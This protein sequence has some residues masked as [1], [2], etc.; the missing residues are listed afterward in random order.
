MNVTIRRWAFALLAS[1]ALGCADAAPSEEEP[2]DMGAAPAPAS[3]CAEQGGVMAAGGEEVPCIGPG[4]VGDVPEGDYIEPTIDNADLEADQ[5]RF[6]TQDGD[7]KFFIYVGESKRIGVRTVDLTGRPVEGQRIGFTLVESDANRPS[8]ASL[9]AQFSATNEF[10]VADIQVTA[11]PQPSFFY[12]LMEA[13]GLDSLRYQISVVQRPEGRDVVEPD[14]NDPNPPV[15]PVGGNCMET[16]GLYSITNNYEPGRF[17]GDG[18]F[19]ALETIHQILSDPGGFVGDLI[20]DRIGG[21]WG[22]LIRGAIRPVINYLY[23]YVVRNYA[24]D[25]LRATLLIVEDVTSLLV[26]LEIQGE[27]DLGEV[28]DM[29]ELVGV[30]RWQTLIFHWRAGCPAGDDRCGRF[31]VPLERLGASASETEFTARVVRSFGPVATMEIDEHRLSLNLGVAVIWFLQEVI[32]PARFNVRSFGELLQLVLPCDAVGALAADYLSGV[33]IIG[34]AVGAFVEEACERG[35]EAAGNQLTRLLSDQLNVNT[36]PM[37]GECKLRDTNADQLADKL[38]D[39]RW[40][41]GLEGD[42]E[43]ERVR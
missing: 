8:E 42:F 41:V 13:D 4:D 16:K 40:S 35:M 17:L 33:P 10:G 37:A 7:G 20:R 32:L 1:L 9:S 21:V 25:W 12:L 22:S 24:P 26:E 27:M 18:P 23:D 29:C 6:L 15:P 11:G 5:Q 31:E 30:H 39:G 3:A 2:E 14:P 28:D 19:Q 43:G 36:F 38:E 34:L